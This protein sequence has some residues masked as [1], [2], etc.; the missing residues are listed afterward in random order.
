MTQTLHNQQGFALAISMALL[1]VVIGAFLLLFAVLGVNQFNLRTQQVCREG[2]L[3]GQQQ[4][5]PL[6]EK[7]LGL[8][9]KARNLKRAEIQAQRQL[10]LALASKVPPAIAAARAYLAAVQLQRRVLDIQ[11]KQILVQSNLILLKAHRA[12]SR[13]LLAA[14]LNGISAF[15]FLKVKTQKSF[16]LP[17]TLAVSPEYP[18]VAPPYRTQAQ[19]E[20]KQALAHSWHYQLTVRSSFQNFLMGD[21][22]WNPSC[23]VT[24]K[25]EGQTWITKIKRAKSW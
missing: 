1:P 17:P 6:L 20:D 18:D 12:T 11:Q 23:A 13:D 14:L 25:Q 15:N 4:V 21:L 2:G 3:R 7:L 22:R 16:S 10:Q 9:N 8:N 5:A 19:F 24:L